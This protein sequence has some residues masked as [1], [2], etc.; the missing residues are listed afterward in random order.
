MKTADKYDVEI[1]DRFPYINSR[2]T[3]EWSSEWYYIFPLYDEYKSNEEMWCCLF[4]WISLSPILVHTDA[5]EYKQQQK[6][7]YARRTFAK[8]LSDP[9]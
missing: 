7:T 5:D 2:E 6:T 4:T 3:K 8:Q 1:V 9:M